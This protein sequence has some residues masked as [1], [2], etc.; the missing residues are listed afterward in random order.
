[1]LIFFGDI[2]RTGLAVYHAQGLQWSGEWLSLETTANMLIVFA[3]YSVAIALLSLL[4][5]CYLPL[6]AVFRP[7]AILLFIG[8]TSSLLDVW[9]FW[10]PVNWF[11]SSIQT[12]ITLSAIVAAFRLIF[13][14]PQGLRALNLIRTQPCSQESPHQDRQPSLISPGEHHPETAQSWSQAEYREQAE[15]ILQE[16]EQFLRNI[17][18][19]AAE[20]IWVVE[21]LED[22]E[23]QIISANRTFEKLSGIPVD[24]WIGKRLDQL[25]SSE[26]ADTIRLHYREGLRQGK[27]VSYEEVLP[28]G[29]VT[30][31]FLTT[32]TPLP[33]P[34]ARVRLLGVSMDITD[35]KQAEEKLRQS[36]I[37]RRALIQAIPDLLIRMNKDGTQL[38]LINQGSVH[39]VGTRNSFLGSKVSEVL[40]L[41]VA[42]N[43]LRC[44]EQALQTG[45]VQFHEYQLTIDGQHFYE[46]AR[47]ASLQADEVLIMVRDI[48]D[49]KQIEQALRES[50][51]RFRTLLEDLQVGVVV[52]GAQTE[53][54]LSNS[55]AADLLGLTESQFLGKTS[56]DLDWNVI[57]EDG[58]PFPGTAHPVSQV[59]A[60]R[61]SVHN[62]IM[63]VYRPKRNDR[64]WLLVD[65]EPRFD[66]DG[67][68]QQVICTFSDISDRQAALREQERVEAELKA[69][70]AF[71]RQVI[72]VVP[73][74]IFV[75]DPIGRI[76]IVNQAGA[77]AHGTT[78]EAMLGKREIDFNPNFTDE[79]LQEFLAINQQVMQ[80]RQPQKVM[81]QSIVSAT[82]ETCWYQTIINPLVDVAGHV[83]GIVGATTD[84]TDLKQAEYALQHAKE[85][86]EAANRA[87]SLF[88]ANMSHELRTPLNVIL[89]FAQAMY[90]DPLLTAKQREN[91]Q[92]IRRSGDH[93]LNLINDVLD[94]SKIEAGHITL[95]ESSVD[96]IDLL[97][98]LRQMFRQ[99]AEAKGLQLR[100]ELAANLP[101]YVVLD[102]KKL[103][104]VLINLLS[105]AVKFTQ[106][107]EVV[108]QVQLIEQAETQDSILNDRCLI[109]FLVKDTGVGID[110][111]EIETIFD[112]FMQTQAGKISPDGTGLGLT[113]SRKFV[114]IMGG[115]ISAHSTLN[116]GST[117]AFTLPLR[118]ARSVDV[119]SVPLVRQVVGLAPNQP[120]YRVLVVD[121]QPENRRLLLDFFTQIGLEVRASENG[122]EA[123]L[124]WQQWQPHLIWMDICMPVLDGY[125]ATQKIR[126]ISEGHTPIIIALTAQASKEDRTLALAAGCNDYLTK[127]FQEE[128]LLSKLAEHLGLHFCTKEPPAT[129]VLAA[130]ISLCPTDLLSMPSSWI[131]ELRQAARLCDDGEIEQL[132]QQIPIE[133]TDLAQGLHQ[134]AQ[135]YNFKQIVDLTMLES[136]NAR[137]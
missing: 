120:T 90:R 10:H 9:L 63:G 93:L 84:V 40:P 87:K 98:S 130:A 3:Y 99:R 46:E 123:V 105:N 7:L 109:H 34:Q 29:D 35:R 44:A 12:I 36:E 100:F 136:T 13:V 110:S 8:G 52:H 38:E 22:G 86:A 4:R 74:V 96:L 128:V 53:V 112:A 114:Q 101:Q 72:D 14:L 135:D 61:Q 19:S 125:E 111:S 77:V 88:L 54:L 76:V 103:R 116:Q 118:L 124:Q 59:I 80:T 70:Q 5:Q 2:F 94:L 78:V 122:E 15:A 11:S 129:G 97:Q 37:T 16:Q 26:I 56:F 33:D 115:D 39:F 102:V 66:Q 83:N 20:A 57:H 75:K 50:E 104:Q 107:G 47:I 127:P 113:I 17:Y 25:W 79:Q 69:Q 24:Q 91:L 92:I 65:A 85:A 23:F 43:R 27:T 64:V 48:T 45:E 55:K 42:H 32:L 89:G 131:E 1:M 51:S 126:E 81:S 41:E 31:C 82:G 62:V 30:R 119:T 58:S 121:D 108:L 28:L 6:R 137:I 106:Q 132:I 71:L 68:V 95:D 49:R 18:D 133:Q 134:L 73:N 117:F 60:T 21:Q 67:I